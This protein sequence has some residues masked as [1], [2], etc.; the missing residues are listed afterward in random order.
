MGRVRRGRGEGATTS[1]DC[2]VKS[3][4]LFRTNPTAA[5]VVSKYAVWLLAAVRPPR[6]PGI[7]AGAEIR[8]GRP[9]G[10]RAARLQG[11]DGWCSACVPLSLSL[12]VTLSV[13][14][15]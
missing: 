14:C 7:K 5:T 10:A 2:L 9:A 11:H 12:P 13:F 4:C 15:L 8:E 1:L 3:W 6:G